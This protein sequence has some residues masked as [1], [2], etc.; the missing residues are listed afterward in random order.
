[1]LEARDKAYAP[2][3]YDQTALMLAARNGNTDEWSADHRR[4]R[5][6][7]ACGILAHDRMEQRI[8]SCDEN[9]C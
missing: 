5:F 6:G 2:D 7:Y 9:G 4:L 3:R 8:D 1:M